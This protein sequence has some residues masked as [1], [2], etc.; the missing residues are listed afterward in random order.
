MAKGQEI[1]RSELLVLL[2]QWQQGV[3]DERVVHERAESRMDELVEL[4]SYPE[5]DPRSIPVEV[6][7]HLDA[8]NHQLITPKDIPVIQQFLRT[9]PGNETQA[10]AVWRDY[11]AN[12]DLESRRQELQNKPYYST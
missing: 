9:P 3:I 6:L 11:W 10:W 12:L 4:A 7:L 2:E 1:E 5:D 8:L